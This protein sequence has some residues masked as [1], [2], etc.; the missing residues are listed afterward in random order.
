MPLTEKKFFS[1]DY[2]VELS[3]TGAVGYSSAAYAIRNQLFNDPCSSP[4]SES[5]KQYNMGK[6]LHRGK[7]LTAA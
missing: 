6:T 5:V 2:L 3:F 1:P 4:R 7:I